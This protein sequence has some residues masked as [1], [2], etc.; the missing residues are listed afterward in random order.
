MFP[1]KNVSLSK[2]YYIWSINFTIM[3]NKKKKHSSINLIYTKVTVYKN[4]QERSAVSK[5]MNTNKQL[6]NNCLENNAIA[7]LW[8]PMPLIPR[9]AEAGR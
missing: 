2:D 3:L 5:T 1:T 7:G 9:Q 6:E 4:Q 8:W